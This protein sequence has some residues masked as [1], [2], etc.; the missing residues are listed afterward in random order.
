MHKYK[1]QVLNQNCTWYI[2]TNFILQNLK[3]ED[4]NVDGGL[5]GCDTM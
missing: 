3:T 4:S 5:L 1:A 2:A